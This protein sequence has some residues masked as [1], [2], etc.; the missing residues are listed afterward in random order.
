[1]P[2]APQLPGTGDAERV[3]AHSLD[4]GAHGDQATGQV[5]NLRL[6]GGVGKHRFPVRQDRR[7][8]GVFRPPHRDHGKDDMGAFQAAGSPGLDVALLQPDVGAE[9]GQRLQVQVQGSGADGAAPRQGHPGMA[10]A[11]QQGAENQDGRPHLAHQVVWRRVAYVGGREG[12]TA[13]LIHVHVHPELAQEMGHGR[14]IHQAG[15]VGQGQGLSSEQAGR[16][17]RQG[18]VLGPA[19]GDG[20]GERLAA[21]DADAVHG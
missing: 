2:G 5:G 12:A 15:N 14:D 9:L 8:Q 20:A 7:H 16:H 18:G 13:S 6:A 21:Q 1:M 11:R 3:A 4:V 19:D 17:Q 10:E